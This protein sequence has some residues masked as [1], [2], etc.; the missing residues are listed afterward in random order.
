MAVLPIQPGRRPMFPPAMRIRPDAHGLV[1]LGGDLA[2]ETLIE[3][4]CKGVF[5]W[6]GRP[7]IPWFSPDPR[8]ILIPR[9]FRA[10][11]ILRRLDR[12]GEWVVRFDHDFA[13][14]MAA[15]AT[16]AR[17]REEGTWIDRNIVE[18]YGRLHALG[19]AHSVEV[20]ADSE[21]VGG[22]YGLA[23]GRA[24]FGESMFHRRTD[25]SKLALW[26]LC[27]RLH[28]AGYRFVDCQQDTGHLRSLGAVA[29]PRLR[30]LRLLEEAVA[31]DS[32][33]DR[34]IA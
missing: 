25:A 8:M 12:R 26:H 2:P 21:L 32:Q 5:P 31:H 11:R 15:C 7:P 13:A 19:V 30:Y 29:I 28:R 20:W 14:V 1:A 9:A 3:A 18:A 22:L 24:F 27:R 16:V 33:W 23:I 17:R 6:E 4:Y 10:N 34:V